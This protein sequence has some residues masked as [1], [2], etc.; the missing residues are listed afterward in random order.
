MTT[1]LSGRR[2]GVTLA[3][4]PLLAGIDLDLRRGEILRIV[5]ASGSGKSTLLRVLATLQPLSA[6]TLTY[7][8]QD[9]ARLS[10]Q[11]FRRL[12]AFIPQRPPM[13]G[14]TVADN[15]ALGLSFRGERLQ[16]GGAAALLQHAGLP[17]SFAAREA[18]TLSG[19]EQLRVALARALALAPQA[20]LLDEP[21]AALDD[22]ASEALVKL[23]R[24][25]SVAG[26][27]IAIVSHDP[28]SLQALPGPQLTLAG[29]RLAAT[30]P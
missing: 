29:G 9:V 13:A 8:G 19:G 2:L 26:A 5:G 16:E 6:G 1:L 3:G 15:L 11:T 4:K 17:A 27:A 18:R 12:V 28:R 23:L 22:Q 21:T 14:G 24:S 10:P 20:F 25:L 7:D 30:P